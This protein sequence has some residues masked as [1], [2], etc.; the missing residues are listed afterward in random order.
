MGQ[1]AF[2]G[3]QASPPVVSLG[4]GTAGCRDVIAFPSARAHG[5]PWSV[6]V[7]LQSSQETSLLAW[8]LSLLADRCEG[9]TAE[10]AGT[11]LTTWQGTRDTGLLRPHPRAG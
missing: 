3:P 5:V 8:D 6:C 1:G 10:E 4:Q 9:M 7:G 11:G 2:V